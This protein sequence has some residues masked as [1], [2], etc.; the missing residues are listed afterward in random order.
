MPETRADVAGLS[1]P[2]RRN[3]WAATL[4]CVVLLLV[5][6]QTTASVVAIWLRSET[7]AHGFLI[8]PIVL[9]LVWDRRLDLRGRSA[10]PA[11]L[12]AL[13]LLPL[14]F[15]WLVAHLVDVLVVQQLA[16]VGMAIVTA[17]AVLGHD[18]GRV[19]AF[20]LLFLFFAVPMGEA[21]I[22]PLMEFTATSTVWLIQHTGIPVYREGLYFTLPTGNWSVVEAC[23]GSRYL[24]ASLTLGVLYA[25]LTYRSLWRRLLFVLASIIVPI[26]ANS[27]RAY[28]IVMLGHL[29]DMTIATGVDHLIYGWVFFGLVIFLLFWVG[30]FFRE[31]DPDTDAAVPASGPARSA[32]AASR[33]TALLLCLALAAL[34]PLLAL[35]LSRGGA[36]AGDSALVLPPRLGDFAREEPAAWSWRPGSAVRGDSTAFYRRGERILGLYVQYP[37]GPLDGDVVGSVDDLVER[38]S[39][40]RIVAQDTVPVQLG[41]RRVPVR[42]AVLVRATGSARLLVWSWYRVAGSYTANEYLGKLLQAAAALGWGDG[43]LYRIV[44]AAPSTDVP[45]A[46]AQLLQAFLHE[47][48]AALDAALD[49]PAQSAPR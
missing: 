23:S 30:S 22:P 21:L 35:A 17:W 19:L 25:Y 31:R 49:A 10:R 12:V 43:T 14:G 38:R 47:G 46:A 32:T 39:A 26:I 6:Y 16:M 3:L 33:T 15:T 34:W 1:A 11:P 13:L 5:Y 18:L 27:L 48:C 9:W 41:A 40:W 45:E 2:V 8:V 37:E 42:Q 24:I 20:P 7:Y 4:G 36:G 29:S 28:I 44:L